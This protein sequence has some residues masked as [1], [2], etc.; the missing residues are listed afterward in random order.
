[1]SKEAKN[2][3]ISGSLELIVKKIKSLQKEGNLNDK[4]DKSLNELINAV[5]EIKTFFKGIRKLFIILLSLVAL[6][7]VLLFI[8]VSYNNKLKNLNSELESLKMDSTMQKILDFKRVENK[9]SISTSYSYQVRNDEVVTYNDLL[10][11]QD[12]LLNLMKKSVKLMDSLNLMNVRLRIKNSESEQKMKMIRENYG[13]EFQEFYKIKNKDTINYLSIE[14][15]KIDSAFI[16]LE[17]YR[18]NLHYD[19]DKDK[20]YIIEYK[21]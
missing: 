21:S 6:L 15:K 13:I 18:K 16:L 17:K 10:K 2:E 14:G 11:Q 5:G 3:S 19:K 1:M 9:D 20:W 7:I 4:D 12:S 8:S